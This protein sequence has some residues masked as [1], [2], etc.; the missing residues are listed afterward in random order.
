MGLKETP[1]LPSSV[2]HPLPWERA[3]ILISSPLPWGEG[4]PPPAFSP[5]GVGRVRGLFAGDAY[6]ALEVCDIRDF[7][8][9]LP[10]H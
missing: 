5:A 8:G 4:V 6:M 7:D 9:T 1:H 3:V 10:A 2:G